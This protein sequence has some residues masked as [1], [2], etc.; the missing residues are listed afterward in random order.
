MTVTKD[1][2]IDL[3]PVYLSGEAS[4]DT[5]RL[6]EEFLQQ[7]RDLAERVRN[8]WTKALS[9]GPPAAIAPDLELRSLR[10]AHVQ[11]W[12]QIVL[13]GV[14]VAALAALFAMKFTFGPG[15]MQ[16][17][18]AHPLA[19]WGLLAILAVCGTAFLRLRLG[20]RS[21]MRRR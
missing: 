5:S 2:V 19:P 6:V 18:H 15:G 7:D 20:L 10:Q 13:F 3:L 4:A 1:V 17:S 16:E 14:M 8:Q 21:M 11:I 12:S 9:A